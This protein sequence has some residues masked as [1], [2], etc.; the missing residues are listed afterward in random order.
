MNYQNG[1]DAEQRFSKSQ[2]LTVEVLEEFDQISETSDGILQLLHPLRCPMGRKKT[3]LGARI[4]Y[5]AFGK[6]Y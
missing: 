2:L 1:F 4:A 5:Q 3:L 6:S